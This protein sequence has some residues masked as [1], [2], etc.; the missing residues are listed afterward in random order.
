MDSSVDVLPQVDVMP[1]WQQYAVDQAL[2]TTYRNFVYCIPLLILG[3]MVFWLRI[4]WRPR[5]ASAVK[6]DGGKKLIGEGEA[7]ISQIIPYIEPWTKTFDIVFLIA[8]LL[9][10]PLLIL[11]S[12]LTM[13]EI[14]SNPAV[15]LNFAIKFGVMVV[16]SL[17]G[18]VVTRLCAEIDDRGYITTGADMKT[19][20]KVKG[21]KVNYTRKI[22][23]FAAY[24]VPV[25]M[26]SPIEKGALELAWSDWCTLMGFVILI[27]PLRE[28]SSFFMMQFNALDRPED[29][30]HT[31]K[32]IVCGDIVPGMVVIIIF[33]AILSQFEVNGFS[34][35]G[36]TYIFVM[37][38]GLGDG[39]A[40][41]V[42]VHWG[43]HKYK[44]ASIGGSSHRLYTRSWEGSCTV[45]WF[46]YVFIASCWYLFPNA[47]SFW[48]T[49]LF[50]PVIFALAEAK[51][52][53]TMDTPF[54]FLVGGVWALLSLH[55]PPVCDHFLIY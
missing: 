13:P 34:A 52:P 53:H 5:S 6:G 49:M 15:W 32:W 20:S 21:F 50:L 35:S 40:E 54:M 3:L 4:I 18:G 48:L 47:T 12:Y 9:F 22:Q 28:L 36:L 26:A 42:G 29:R 8:M 45:A 1:L 23:H 24:A 38:T 39:F 33:N 2:P 27:K 41:P 17:I 19:K 14:L 30:P 10:F 37:V 46:S 16:A 7:S 51:S 55:I 43:K 44:V 11:S 31:L 25:L